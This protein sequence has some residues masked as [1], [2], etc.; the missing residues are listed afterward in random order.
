MVAVP[1][2]TQTH[3][4][5]KF[6]I[7]WYTMP[8]SR[9]YHSQPSRALKHVLGGG[10]TFGSAGADAT[11]LLVDCVAAKACPAPSDPKSATLPAARAIP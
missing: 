3:S 6:C 11:W 4:P 8:L 7:H 10:G 2:S 5:N 9:S 1:I